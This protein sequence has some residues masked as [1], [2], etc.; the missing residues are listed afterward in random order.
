VLNLIKV[1][2]QVSD[3]KLHLTQT[4]YQILLS[5]SQSVSRVFL[6]GAEAE[7]EFGQSTTTISTPALVD[8]E[9]SSINLE[10]ELPAAGAYKVWTTIDLVLT[11]DAIKL[12]LYG[13]EAH[14]ESNLQQ[15]GIARFALNNS[16]L[17][18]KSIS[19]GAV[20]AQLVLKTFTMSNTEPGNTRFREIIPATQQDRNQFMVLYSMTSASTGTSLAVVTIDSPQIIFSIGPVFALLNF[21]STQTGPALLTQSSTGQENQDVEASATEGGKTLDFRLDL[22]DVAICVLENDQDPN[23]QAIR[24]SIQ[25]LLISQQVRGT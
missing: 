24:L 25:Q 21:F 7:V 15:H 17:R 1:A 16:N 8:S 18:Y 10:L 22:H 2:V 23:T 9:S 11:V 19:D 5:L 14:A 4:Q 13:A 6:V 12:H 3:V 20:E